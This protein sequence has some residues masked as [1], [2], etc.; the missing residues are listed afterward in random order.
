[1]HYIVT[2][3]RKTWLINMWDF[4]GL[5][6]EFVGHSAYN[7]LSTY[8]YN[9]QWRYRQFTQLQST[10]HYSMHWVLLV[11]C[12]TLVLGYQVP[13]ADVPLPGFLN[14]SHSNSWLTVHSLE[15]VP[16]TN[17]SAL[18]PVPDALELSP[19][20]AST[21]LLSNTYFTF[22]A[23]YITNLLYLSSHNKCPSQSQSYIMTGGQ[24]VSLSCCQAP[25]WDPRY[26]FLLFL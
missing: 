17:S 5:D 21:G 10:V 18:C 9:S 7:A 26:N 20:T 23:L 24:L 6:I 25:I 3:G 19:I 22:G 14:Y 8:H 16:L 2:N 12:H 13:M 4:F 11:Y 15:L 1:M